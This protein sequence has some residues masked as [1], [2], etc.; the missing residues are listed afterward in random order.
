M[1]A[2]WLEAVVPLALITTFIVMQ[3]GL[4]GAVQQAFYG[5]PKATDVDE[6]DRLVKARDERLVEE[7]KRHG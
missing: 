5:K 3:G 1:L 7:W 4:Q 2:P 6:W